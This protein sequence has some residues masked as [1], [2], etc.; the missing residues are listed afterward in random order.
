VIDFLLHEKTG[1]TQELSI[2]SWIVFP[3]V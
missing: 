3:F 1:H 2:T